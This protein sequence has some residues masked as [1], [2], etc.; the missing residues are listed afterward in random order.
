MAT[1]PSTASSVIST[2]NRLLHS[3]RSAVITYKQAQHHLKG[4]H[5]VD[6]ESNAIC[7]HQRIPVLSQRIL[8]LGGAPT[9]HGEMWIGFTRGL[10]RLLAAPDAPSLIAV[11]AHG[12]ELGLTQYKAALNR[13]D[14]LSRSMLFN[15][16]LPDQERTQARMSM[17]KRTAAE[18]AL[19]APSNW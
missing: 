12:E 2:L 1:Q 8:E 4:Q 15:D 16:L 17:A 9:T 7:H 5:G 3:E 18:R 14:P 6:L 11:L 19:P 10:E 13:L